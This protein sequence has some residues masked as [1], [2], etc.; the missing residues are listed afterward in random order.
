MKKGI[1]EDSIILRKQY[2]NIEA[3]I[4][5]GIE[6]NM[7]HGDYKNQL[8]RIFYILI[9]SIEILKKDQFFNNNSIKILISQDL[10]S[11]ILYMIS[12][13]IMK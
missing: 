9:N 3:N 7:A 13:I 10:S 6:Q 5:D 1:E 12:S 2:S 8:S 11:R 4:Y